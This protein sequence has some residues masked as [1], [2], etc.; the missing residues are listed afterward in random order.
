MSLHF[1]NH[2]M[3]H[4]L[5]NKE[6]NEMYLSY[7]IFNFALGLISVFIPIYLYK[8]GYSIPWVIFFFFLNS[9]AF[10]AFSYVGVRVVSKIGVKY[11][12][13][14]TGPIL[15]VFFVGLRYLDTYPML[16]FVLPILRAFKMILYNYSFHLNFIKHSDKK[17]RGKEVSMINAS[18]AFA[19]MISPFIGGLILK[20]TNFPT[21]FSIGSF[22]LIAAMIPLFFSK[23]EYAGISFAKKNLFSEIFKRENLPSVLSF[24]GYAIESWIGFIIWPIFLYVTLVNFEAV[25]IVTSVAAIL[26]FVIFYFIGK[27]T[28]KRDKRAMLRFGTILYFF[29][30]LGRIFVTGIGSAFV[31][32]S[33]KNLSQ[34][35][36]AIP[37]SAY[38]YDLAA[39]RDYF[40]FIVRREV[41]FNLSRVIFL[42]VIMMIFY[43]DFHAFIL[44]F[45]M[46][47]FASIFYV[48][49]GNEVA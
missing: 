24:S 13:L 15:I 21:L 26:T 10:V 22:F 48:S 18:A 7:G 33:Y 6:M 30:W 37:W 35:V 40:K 49:L 29:G 43:F 23:E 41:I 19:G 27:A 1:N 20:F 44:A 3:Q 16:F 17:E 9:L 11:A 42:P 36:V 12:M 31:I 5:R 46:A 34:Q 38:F 47:A 32:D 4:F 2:H 45:S 14:I 39:K 8:L 25:G 28:D